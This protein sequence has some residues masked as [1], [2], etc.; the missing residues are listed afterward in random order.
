MQKIILLGHQAYTGNN[1]YFQG[2]LCQAYK[3]LLAR[4]VSD[5]SAVKTLEAIYNEST[6]YKIVDDIEVQ[7]LRD[8]NN[9]WKP[10]LV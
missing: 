4:G 10:E 7:L 8:P 6:D 2:F 9:N 5:E 3:E 1:K